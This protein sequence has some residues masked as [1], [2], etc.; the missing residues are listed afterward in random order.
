MS[1]AGSKWPISTDLEDI[2]ETLHQPGPSFS[3]PQQSFGKTN[4]VRRSFQHCW[5]QKWPF[6]HYKESA[7]V[8]FFLFFFAILAL[9]V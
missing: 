6:L 4:V 2:P 1:S 9:I 8:V 5:F 7:D 3:F